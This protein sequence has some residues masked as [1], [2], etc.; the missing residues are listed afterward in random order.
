MIFK[1]I[2]EIRSGAKTQ[3]RRIIHG[4][5]LGLYSDGSPFATDSPYF[6]YSQT[7]SVVMNENGRVRYEVG[8]TYAVVPK[9]GQ[10]AVKDIRI[11]ITAIRKEP[12]QAISYHDALAEGILRDGLV[13]DEPYAPAYYYGGNYRNLDN[14]FILPQ[15]A[16]RSLWN[17]I[18][19]R[20]GMRWEDNPQVWVLTFEAGK[21]DG[22]E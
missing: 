17:S 13:P 16:Y 22:V 12:V 18:N 11:K 5:D 4:V 21:Q 8:K 7:V 20:P 14:Y 15:A 2:G 1:Q 9:R 19:K 6:D 3:T 10:A